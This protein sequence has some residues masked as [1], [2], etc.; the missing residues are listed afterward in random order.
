MMDYVGSAVEKVLHKWEERDPFRLAEKMDIEILRLPLGEHLKGYFFYFS[1]IAIIVLNE[2]M[3]EPLQRVVCA[4]ELGH[5]VLHKEL[6]MQNRFQEFTLFNSA[7]H[8]ELEANQFAAELLVEDDALLPLLQE[9]FTLYEAASNLL[10]PPELVVFKLQ[11][12]KKKGIPVPIP[13][14]AAGNFLKS[15]AL[16]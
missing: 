12:L 2:S 15:N 9:G 3:S 5:A 10:V 7:I 11:M 4:H 1:R 14:D 6:A 16:S 13:L 8:T